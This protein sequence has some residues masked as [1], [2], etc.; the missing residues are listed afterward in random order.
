MSGVPAAPAARKSL[1]KG[2]VLRAQ[3]FGGLFPAAGAAQPQKIWDFRST[4]K[5]RIKNPG[6][7]RE[8]RSGKSLDGEAAGTAAL[9]RPGDQLCQETASRVLVMLTATVKH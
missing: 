5:P 1:Q 4:Q 7:V 6:L 3:P 2:E 9:S 8:R